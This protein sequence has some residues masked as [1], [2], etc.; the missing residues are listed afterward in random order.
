MRTLRSLGLCALI[1][2][3]SCNENMGQEPT[4][5]GAQELALAGG[6][7]GRTG[8][9]A[10][11]ANADYILIERR[12]FLDQQGFDRPVE[13]FSVL[14]PKDWKS[15]G[16]VRWKGVNECR[17]EIVTS[18]LSITSPDRSISFQSYPVRAFAWAPDEMMLQ[19]LMAGAQ[20]GDCAVNQPFSAQ[21][22]IQG[23]AQQDLQ[24][25]ASNITL[26]EAFMSRIQ[27]SDRQ[28]N[29]IARQFGNNS[30]QT[31]TFANGDLT[32][33]DGTQGSISAGV[34][35][36]V[37]HKQNYVT[38]GTDM[39]SSTMVFYCVVMRYPKER[40]SE[41]QRMK[42][43]LTSSYRVNPIWQK[44]KDNFLTQLGNMEHARNMDKIRL[45]GEQ[46]QAYAK[47]SSDAADRQMR[48]WERSQSSNDTQHTQ[49][50]KAIREVETYDDGANGRVELNSGYDHAWSR[51]DGSYILS[52]S[53]N[54]DPSS[55]FQDQQ[56]KQ[57]RQVP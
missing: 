26:D 9:A 32:W 16:G 17:G 37:T 43:L 4:D 57:M 45:M 13:A 38:G 11:D 47:S 52:N 10:A 20:R 6:T 27:Q 31:T 29:D 7:N 54:F 1:I 24:A 51:G 40:K 21:E 56:W 2:L 30:E 5:A 50:V 14:C 35:N 41:A 34:T 8:L 22:Y 18:S 36:V 48:N 28:A 3:M 42:A 55:V 49:F 15:E 53:P 33:P 44:A 39:N 19:I 46:A 12:R 23:F 25:Q